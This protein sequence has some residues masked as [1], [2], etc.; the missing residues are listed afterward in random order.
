MVVT[1]SHC[2]KTICA[3]LWFVPL[4]V[5]FQPNISTT[6]DHNQMFYSLL[7]QVQKR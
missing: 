4:E 2:P 5:T 1:T 7:Q 3:V 6:T